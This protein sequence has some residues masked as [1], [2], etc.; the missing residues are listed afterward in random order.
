[1]TDTQVFPNGEAPVNGVVAEPVRRRL[2]LA[3]RDAKLATIMQRIEALLYEARE[4]HTLGV[5]TVIPFAQLPQAWRR[6]IHAAARAVVMHESLPHQQDADV[7]ARAYV[8][9]W[10]TA[11]A[12]TQAPW[13]SAEAGRERDILAQFIQRITRSVGPSIVTEV[14]HS[15]QGAL[16]GPETRT[17]SAQI[18]RAMF[19]AHTTGG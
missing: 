15:Y 12:V 6:D 18:A 17:P 13:G 1:M 4:A 14:R 5:A 16:C 10:L 7:A 19:A 11:E 3:E 9:R 2:T 8:A